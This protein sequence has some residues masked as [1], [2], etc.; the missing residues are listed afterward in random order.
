MAKWSSMDERFEQRHFDREA[1]IVCVRGYLR[2][3]LNLRDLVEMMAER[4]LSLAHATISALGG[5]RYAPEFVRRW[6]RFGWPAGRSRRVDETDIRIR[7]RWRYLYRAVDRAGKAVDFHPSARRSVAAARVFFAEAL[8]RQGAPRTITLDGHAA[9]RRAVRGQ[10]APGL[11]PEAT[12]LCASKPLNN[13]I[14]QDHGHVRLRIGPMLGLKR[15]GNAAI[16]IAGIELMHRSLPRTGLRWAGCASRTPMR[17]TSGIRCLGLESPGDIGPRSSTTPRVRTRSLR[18]TCALQGAQTA[19]LAV[20][21]CT[22][23]QC[24]TLPIGEGGLAA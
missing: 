24:G 19:R 1:I 5:E 13:L 14:E 3:T 22:T 16:P 18:P 8:R 23:W 2:Y 7:G 20:C 12:R 17:P 4:D 9:S 21:G 11:L 10:Q 6:S 15:F